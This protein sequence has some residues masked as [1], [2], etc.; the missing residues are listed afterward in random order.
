MHSVDNDSKLNLAVF[1]PMFGD[2]FL[3]AKI[4]AMQRQLDTIMFSSPCL[5][6]FF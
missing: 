4:A 3:C 1:V 6:I 2:L 5:G